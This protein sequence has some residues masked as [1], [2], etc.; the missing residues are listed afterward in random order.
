M[1][2]EK[3]KFKVGDTT[4]IAKAIQPQYESIVSEDTGRTDDGVM[5]IT[6]VKPIIRKYSIEMPPCSYADASAILSLVQGK[7][8]QFTIFDPLSNSEKTINAYTS[9]SNA[10]VYSGVILNGLIT[11]LTFN[12]IDMNGSTT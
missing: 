2:I 5:H 12:V 8:Y 9:N 10:D 4:F 7:T 1:P 11:G 6:W 3:S